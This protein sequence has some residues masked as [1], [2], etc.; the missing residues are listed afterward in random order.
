MLTIDVITLFPEM[1]APAIG[2]SIVG[3]AVERGLVAV[4]MPPPARI[5]VWTPSAPTTPRTAVGPGWCLRLEPLARALDAILAATPARRA[6]RTR[7]DEPGRQA[8]RADGRR[9][10]RRRWTGWSWSADTTKGST[11]VCGALYPLEEVSLGDFILTGGEIPA[12]AVLDATVRLIEGAIRAESLASES[13]TEG[14][15]LDHP[16]FTR[17]PRFR[18]V[19]VPEVL[20]SG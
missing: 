14:D 8:L 7:P 9:A 1:F 19:D 11:I 12:L 13:F 4:R 20:L 17:P 5:T 10:F 15:D 16:S 3:R 2:L 6:A 18:G